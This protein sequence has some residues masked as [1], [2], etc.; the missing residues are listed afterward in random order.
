[1]SLDYES[2]IFL[3]ISFSVLGPAVTF[4]VHSNLQNISTA[5]V[6]KEAGKSLSSFPKL[7]PPMCLFSSQYHCKKHGHILFSQKTDI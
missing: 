1:M 5:D 2:Y 7:W 6:A 3:I 4:R